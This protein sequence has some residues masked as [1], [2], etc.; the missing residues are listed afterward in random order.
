MPEFSVA[1]IGASQDR[2]KFGNKAVR[3][4]LEFG[5]TVFPVNPKESLI[6]GLTTYPNIA[7]IPSRVDF[8]SLYVPPAVG[9]QLLPAI[10]AKEPKELWLN[11]GS[12]SDELIEAAADL[13]LRAIVACS[14]LALGMSPGDFPA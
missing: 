11:P 7:A 12:E 1:V 5:Y 6:E 4:Y 9:L 8:V 3:A 10:A 2:R 14:L 13:H